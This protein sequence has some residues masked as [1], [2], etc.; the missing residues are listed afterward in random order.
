MIRIYQL[1]QLM[2][3]FNKKTLHFSEI[4]AQQQLII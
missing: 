2:A 4:Q 3:D 1:W